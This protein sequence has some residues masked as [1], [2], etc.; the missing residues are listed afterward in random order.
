MVKIKAWKARVIPK[1]PEIHLRLVEN[2]HGAAGV[3]VVAC[4]EDGDRYSRGILCT[5]RNDGTIVLHRGVNQN[6]G[7]KLGYL[8]AIVTELE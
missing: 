4:Y 5:F 2:A 8:G 1:D 6:I 3:S 7:M